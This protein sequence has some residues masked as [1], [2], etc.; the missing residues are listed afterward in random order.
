MSATCDRSVV[1]QKDRFPPPMQLTATIELIFLKVSL[2][3][4]THWPRC[5][6][7]CYIASEMLLYA[8]HFI[9]NSIFSNKSENLFSLFNIISA[10]PGKN[11]CD[12]YNFR[13][14]NKINWTTWQHSQ[15]I[16]KYLIFILPSIFILK[17]RNRNIELEQFKFIYFYQFW[18]KVKY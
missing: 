1:F 10:L 5:T 4:I 15:Q 6:R 7:L 11:V 14:V 2:N 18:K 9:Y 12:L 8:S 3:T 17:L 16:F 13:P